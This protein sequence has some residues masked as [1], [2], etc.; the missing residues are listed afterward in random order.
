MFASSRLAFSPFE[1][2]DLD[3]TTFHHCYSLW[4]H[5]WTI[6]SNHANLLIDLGATSGEI[7]VENP[8]AGDIPTTGF[9]NNMRK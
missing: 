1:L 8:D 7:I 5:P 6:H 3:E 9:N 4:R 2:E